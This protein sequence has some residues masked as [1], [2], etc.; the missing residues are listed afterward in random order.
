VWEKK[1]YPIL[2][3][4]KLSDYRISTFIC[5]LQVGYPFHL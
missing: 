2:S 4:I 5:G 1:K 3:A